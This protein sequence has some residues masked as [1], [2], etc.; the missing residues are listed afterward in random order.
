V[1]DL[2]NADATP[3]EFHYGMLLSREIAKVSQM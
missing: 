2:G 3:R 1:F